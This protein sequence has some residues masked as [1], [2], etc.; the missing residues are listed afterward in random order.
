VK[1]CP[2]YFDPSSNQTWTTEYKGPCIPCPPECKFKAFPKV[3][4]IDK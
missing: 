3:A 1:L 2:P 4:M